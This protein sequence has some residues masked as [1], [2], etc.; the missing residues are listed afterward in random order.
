MI[1]DQYIDT[2]NFIIVHPQGLLNN[3][4]ETHWN[5]GQLGTSINDVD[6]I[7]KLIDSLSLEYNID[8]DRVYSTGMSNGAI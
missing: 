5:V 2:L 1:L 4:G 7:S 8:H 3:S 6:F